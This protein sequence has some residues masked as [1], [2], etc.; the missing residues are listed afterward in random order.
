MTTSGRAVVLTIVATVIGGVALLI[1]PSQIAELQEPPD[2]EIFYGVLSELD[3]REVAFEQS[4]VS[5]S[6]IAAQGTNTPR[7]YRLYVDCSDD[8][9]PL[10][11]PGNPTGV[12]RRWTSFGGSAG[13]EFASI[14]HCPE[15]DPARY[16]RIVV[17]MKVGGDLELANG[18]LRLISTAGS[19]RFA[20]ASRPAH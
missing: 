4:K 6:V 3:G 8:G 12:G 20:E 17:I 2:A 7:Q 5:V 1:I 18:E 14:M 13:P 16:N 11:P 10:T 9:L 19:A 15:E